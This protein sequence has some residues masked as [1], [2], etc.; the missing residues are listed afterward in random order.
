MIRFI[1][2]ILS[3]AGGMV[4]FI[5]S[6]LHPG[7][8]LGSWFFKTRVMAVWISIMVISAIAFFWIALSGPH[9]EK[10]PHLL[11][12]QN[13]LPVLPDGVITVEKNP[14]WPGSDTIITS[15]EKSAY[16]AGKT[17]YYYY[18]NF[19]HGEPGKNIG[20]VG[21]SFNPKPPNLLQSKIQSL[22]DSELIIRMVAGKSH[23]PLLPYVVPPKSRSLIAKYI[24]SYK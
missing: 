15:S 14:L 22:N 7:T 23:D 4:Q 6:P 10:Q 21:S 3:L 17:Y 8:E 19:C 24:K 2:V 9:M 11:T 5:I 20:S 1:E 16:A 12:Y 18:C 13:A